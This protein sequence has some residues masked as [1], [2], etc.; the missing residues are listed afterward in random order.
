MSIHL[1]IEK[2]YFATQ[3]ML[4]IAQIVWLSIFSCQ[5][6]KLKNFSCQLWQLK[7]GDQIFCFGRHK[8]YNDQMT[9][10]WV[11][12]KFFLSNLTSF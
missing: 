7:I 6:G 5:P 8:V 9:L 11:A 1:M 4:V 3:R 12:F 10:F 2:K